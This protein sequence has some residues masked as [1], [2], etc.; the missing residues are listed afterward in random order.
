MLQIVDSRA[1]RSDMGKSH[2]AMYMYFPS[3]PRPRC[4]GLKGIYQ[5]MLAIIQGVVGLKESGGKVPLITAA[6]CGHQQL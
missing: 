2:P 1:L 5:A 6:H 4:F 3:G